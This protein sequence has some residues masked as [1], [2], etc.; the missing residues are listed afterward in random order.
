MLNFINQFCGYGRG[1]IMSFGGGFMMILFTVLIGYLV[2]FY[3]KNNNAVKASSSLQLLKNEF[4]KG[5]INEDEFL[6]K[7]DL[8]K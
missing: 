7:K 8:L 5:N 1:S 2:Y 4:A 3:F 6:R